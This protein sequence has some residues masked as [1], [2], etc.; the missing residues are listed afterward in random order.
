[1]DLIRMGIIVKYSFGRVDRVGYDNDFGDIVDGACLIDTA[2]DSKKFSFCTCYEGSM[3]NC[4][5]NWA[6]E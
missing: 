1:M 4:F 5:D 3:V 2:S 6:I